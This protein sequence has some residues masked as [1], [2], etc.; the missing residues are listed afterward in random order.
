MRSFETN[1]KRKRDQIFHEPDS[2]T[3]KVLEAVEFIFGLTYVAFSRKSLM[4]KLM[5]NPQWEGHKILNAVSNLEKGSFIR[6]IDKD[7]YRLTKKGIE[8][9]NFSKFFKLSLDKKK[10]DGL[11]RVVIFDVPEEQRTKRDLLRQKLKEF[12]FQMMQKSV[13][14]SPYVCEKEIKELCKILNLNNEVCIIL[15]KDLGGFEEKLEI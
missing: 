7:N 6:K 5:M 4:R 12:D 1:T 2:R 3:S 11:W 10:K 9:I 8:R 14:V 15:A 13:L